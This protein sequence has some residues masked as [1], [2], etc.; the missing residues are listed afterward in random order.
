MSR[1]TSHRVRRAG[2]AR[3]LPT[4]ASRR[5][6]PREALRGVRR[7]VRRHRVEEAD[8]GAIRSRR[9]RGPDRRQARDASRGST[10]AGL[11]LTTLML[12]LLVPHQVDT[13]NAIHTTTAAEMHHK[14]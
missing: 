8:I 6:D 11:A 9:T 4:V 2:I 13:H 3:R 7:G 1:E 12:M 5:E 10:H 14:T